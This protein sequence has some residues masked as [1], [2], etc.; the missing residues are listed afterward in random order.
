MDWC[1]LPPLSALRSFAALA[2]E[3]S[4]SRAGA[5]LNV[6]HAAVSQQVRA[7]EERLGTALVQREG[8]G[9][10]LTPAGTQLA[11]TLEA[12]FLAIR[13]AVDEITGAD[14]ARPLQVSMTPSFA[15]SWLMPRI[16][17]FRHRHPEIELMLNPTPELVDLA[18]GGIDV[19]IRFGGGSWAGL[20]SE[21]LLATNFVIVAARSMIGSRTISD[22]REILDFPW[23]QELG[24]NEMSNWLRQRGVL[25]PKTGN[26]THLPGHMLLEVPAQRRG[27][28]GDLAGIRRTGH[29]RRPTVGALRGSATRCGLLH[30]HPPRRDAPTAQ[31]LRRLAATTGPCP[32]HAG[33][34]APLI[35]ISVVR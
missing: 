34:I 15:V 18:P 8:R 11:S 35:E 9:T 27:R 21:L 4:F 26:I 19:A 28:H 10:A 6:S 1:T 20:Q 3:G 22:P 33:V 5:V 17:E 24:T 29:R 23:L 14:A 13:R 2:Q 16:A 31:G 32:T 7:L 30:R 12:S 25:A